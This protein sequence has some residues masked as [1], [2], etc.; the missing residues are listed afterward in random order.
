MKFLL[1]AV[2]KRRA[3]NNFASILMHSSRY[4]IKQF[5]TCLEIANYSDFWAETSNNETPNEIW[6]R[7]K[8][9][10][11]AKHRTGWELR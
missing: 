10:G 3:I 2:G 11:V 5:I 4:M 1:G 7:V 8:H 9:L 6:M